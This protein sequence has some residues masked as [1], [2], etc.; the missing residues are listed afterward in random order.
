MYI[1]YNFNI[2]LWVRSKIDI[3]F[4]LKSQQLSFTFANIWHD[5]K[6]IYL[7]LH[8]TGC[9]SGILQQHKHLWTKLTYII[10]K[11]KKKTIFFQF[12]K[13]KL[14]IVSKFK[15]VEFDDLNVGSNFSQ[16]LSHQCNLQILVFFPPFPFGAYFSFFVST[17]LHGCLSIYVSL[18]WSFYNH[19]NNIYNILRLLDILLK[20]RF[21]KSEMKRIY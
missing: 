5:Y 7:H 16:H 15:N 19:G 2:E 17:L 10:L 18:Q 1:W 11:V 9:S 8:D 12:W 6:N 21:T 13:C 3:Y 14:Y 20:F 4:T